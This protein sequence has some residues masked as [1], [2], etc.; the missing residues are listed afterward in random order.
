M[1]VLLTGSTGRVG[2]FLVPDLQARYE[3]RTFDFEANPNVEQ[4]YAGDVADFESLR[5]AIAGVETVIH[6]AATS[7]EAP[8]VE[9][10]VPN[11]VIGTYNVLEAARVEKVR[12]VIFAST[13]QAV[14]CYPGE[15]RVEPNDPPRPSTLYGATKVLGEAMGRYYHDRHGLEF[16]AIRIE[17][18]Q[19]YDSP[20]LKHLY[21]ERVWLSPRDMV[22]LL[23]K[24]IETPAVGYAVVNGTSRTSYEFLSLKSAQEILGYIPQDNSS[25]YFPGKGT[26]S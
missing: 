17:A 6:L 16:I 12:R 7:D 2:P 10:L 13:I 5:T 25:D 14:G 23:V 3:L 8:F 4:A 20:H 21:M 11:N 1:K 24:A 15:S 9:Q 26:D 18:F 22:Q 19:P